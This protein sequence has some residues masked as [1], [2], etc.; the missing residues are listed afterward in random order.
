MW[1]P[2][3]PSLLF[4]FL[5]SK[6]PCCLRRMLLCCCFFFFFFFD[7]ESPLPLD[8]SRAAAVAHVLIIS[9]ALSISRHGHGVSTTK[10]ME[11]AA[12]KAQGSIDGD[13]WG[14]LMVLRWM[15]GRVAAAEY[16][17]QRQQ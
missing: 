1:D 15:L 2:W 6:L 16:F 9:M 13:G 10:K 7:L 4:L 12:V 11:E 5:L 17:G 14:Q 8:P 3:A